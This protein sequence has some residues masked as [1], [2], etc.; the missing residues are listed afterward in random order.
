MKWF[1]VLL[2]VFTLFD[3]HP[4]DVAPKKVAQIF[5]DDKKESAINTPVG[6]TKSCGYFIINSTDFGNTLPVYN[7][8]IQL[9]ESGKLVQ[10][11]MTTK[12]GKQYQTQPFNPEKY[13]TISN[14]RHDEVS[15]TISFDLKG[16]LF[17]PTSTSSINVS[18][19]FENL[20]VKSFGCNEVN[21][22]LRGLVQAGNSTNFE[23]ETLNGGPAISSINDGTS[24]R[25]YFQYFTLSNSFR[26]VFESSA[27]FKSLPAGTYKI[28][29]GLSTRFKLVFQEYK[30]LS[31]PYN[32]YVYAAA[33]WQDYLIDG[34]VTITQQTQL[35]GRA[36]T[37]GTISFQALDSSGIMRYE[38]KQGAFT[39]LNLD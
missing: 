3:C 8:Q 5:L 1:L 28:G 19:R 15:K 34:T 9:L 11:Q 21:S 2:S 12:E 38:F 16:K 6:T 23:V 22:E 32:F 36:Y 37:Q 25:T 14:F 33:D 29:S 7:L 18:G 10:L 35:N 13:I 27:S 26:V 4:R 31:N 39:F 17:I 30:G 20:S 24:N